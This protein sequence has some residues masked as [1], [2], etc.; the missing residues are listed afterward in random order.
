M[1]PNEFESGQNKEDNSMSVTRGS[2]LRV[3]TDTAES[4]F[5]ILAQHFSNRPKTQQ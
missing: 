1:G 3:V 4:D 5:T 2:D